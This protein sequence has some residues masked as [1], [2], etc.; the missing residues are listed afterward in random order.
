MGPAFDSRLTHCFFAP[1]SSHTTQNQT[2]LLFCPNPLPIYALNPSSPER[3][4]SGEEGLR[5]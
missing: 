3:G 4:G 1:F 2:S 5:A